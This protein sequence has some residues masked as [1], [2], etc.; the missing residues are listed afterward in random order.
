MRFDK[1]QTQAIETTGTSILVSASAGAGKTGVLVARLIKRCVQDRIPLSRILAVTFTQAAAGEMK[2]RL[3]RQLHEEYEA[4]AEAE[5][6]QY[7]AEQLILLDTANITTIDSYCK[8]VIQKYC[9]VIGLNPAIADH[10]LSESEVERYRLKAFHQ[11]ATKLALDNPELFQQLLMFSSPRP[12]D[13]R[14]LFAL[15]ETI[16]SH[17]DSAVYPKRWLEKALHAA[18]PIKHFSDFP[19]DAIQ[20]FFHYFQLK[21][22]TVEADLK[23]MLANAQEG[24]KIKPELLQ[25]KEILL[26]NCQNALREKNYSL[27]CLSLDTLAVAK[28]AADSNAAVYSKARRHMEDAIREMLARRYDEATLVRDNNAVS[29]LVQALIRLAD[30]Y[31]DRFIALKQ[32]DACMDFTDMERYA[33]RILD[34]NNGEVAAILRTRLDEIMVDEFQDT[35]VLQNAIIERIARKDTVFRVGDIKQSIYRFRQAKPDLMRSL[36]QNPDNR[37]ITLRHN[38]RSK[39]SIVRFT[40]KLFS[41]CM[42]VDGLKNQYAAADQV[43]VGS[44]AQEEET[45]VPVIFAQVEAEKDDTESISNKERKSSWIARTIHE[46]MRNNPQLRFRDFAILIR[47]HADKTFLR[48]AFDRYGIPYDIDAREGFYHSRMAQT[49]RSFVHAVLDFEDNISLAAVLT[50]AMYNLT[51]EELALLKINGG[52][53]NTGVRNL[54]PE[55]MA[56]LEELRVTA[57]DE[58]VRA[59]LS[60][61]ACMHDFIERQDEQERANY[62][63]LFQMVCAGSI[64]T[65]RQFI[66]ML[67]EA[68]DESSSQ[69]LSKGADD[70]VVT[71]TTIHHAKGLQYRYVFL[72]ST[73]KNLFRD[74]SG[75]IVVDDDL[76]V[77]AR[78]IDTTWGAVRPTLP[79]IAVEHKNNLEDLDEFIRL[80]YVAVTR[81]RD[82]LYIVDAVPPHFSKAPLSLPMLNQRNG[83]SGL[84]LSVLDDGELFQRKICSAY[85]APDGTC[86]SKETKAV[87]K[88]YEGPAIPLCTSFTPSGYEQSALP[89]LTLEKRSSGSDYGTF[90][91]ELIARLPNRLWTE[92]DLQ[93]PTLSRRD[94]EHVLAF[95][96]SSVYKKSLRMDIR[97]EFPFYVEEGKTILHGVM[98]FVA[99]GEDNILLVD[100]KTDNADAATL[101][102]RYERQ[103]NAYRHALEHIYRLPVEA[104][105]WSLHNDM[106]V[107]IKATE[108]IA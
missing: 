12:E 21:L 89:P 86:R 74:A 27:F 17:A 41:A 10:V 81:A 100:F 56:D 46:E 83:M 53:L 23:T 4:A 105:I 51:D 16:A 108:S 1:E 70:D 57:R 79:F 91:H 85:A 58:G 5:S 96:A 8:T 19:K 3:A 62:D 35:S 52:S 32:A 87:L 93:E 25:E 29:P 78:W 45:P 48:S 107:P 42:N 40:N 18:E 92:A 94:I 98:D 76:Y 68:Q 77:G 28:T 63:F 72:W 47:G 69:A 99:L 103:L 54:R 65:L 59:F 75:P 55:V 60:R 101:R 49:I 37:F 22:E 33:L 104:Y 14:S 82:R 88:C 67:D 20:S 6:R 30:A 64:T 80:L 11:V 38:Y 7:L 84:L 50:S 97:K 61:L 102:C 106:A 34:A 43:T 2:K 66:N 15:C 13:I 24:K 44:S 9:N 39:E 95:G 90:M 71:V 26:H 73:M 36:M 31:R